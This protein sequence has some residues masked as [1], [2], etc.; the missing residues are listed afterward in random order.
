[1]RPFRHFLALFAALAALSTPVHAAPLTLCTED[2]PQIPWASPDGTGLNLELL[3]RVEKITGDSFTFVYRPWKRCIEELRTGRIDGLIAASDSPV[4]RQF[5]VPPLLPDGTPDPEKAMYEDRSNVFIRV[6]SKASWDGQNFVN[7]RGAIITLA[8]Y[9]VGDLLRSRGQAV[10]DTVK[11]TEDALRMLAAGAADMAVLQS[12]RPVDL[13]LN[14]PRFKGKIEVALQPYAIF[15]F[16]LLIN[17]RM[18]EANP[19]RIDAIWNA[20]H[21]VRA[22]AEYR[23]LEAQET[24]HKSKN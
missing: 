8:G 23:A 3:R 10:K 16:H 22:S 13:A 4:R 14:D 7:P 15:A 5:S 9:Y 11:T 20:I 6:G 12:Q 21:D 2:V 24:R 18:Y 1:M 17:K 19:K